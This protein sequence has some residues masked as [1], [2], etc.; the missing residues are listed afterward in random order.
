MCY[1]RILFILIFILGIILMVIPVLLS[2]VY[3]DVHTVGK[4]HQTSLAK[5]E[6]Y[7]I[8]TATPIIS[9]LSLAL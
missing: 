4:S 9:I 7:F 5:S 8:V 6:V 3:P 1:E 2:P